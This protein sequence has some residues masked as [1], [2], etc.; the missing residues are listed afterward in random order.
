MTLLETISVVKDIAVGGAS[1]FA[2]SVAFYGLRNWQRELRGRSDFD[3]ARNLA[4]ST[5]VLRD[6]L[7]N[8]RSPLVRGS[9][10]PTGYSNDKTKTPKEVAEAWGHLYTGRWKPVGEA[11]QEFDAAVLESEALWGSEIRILTDKLKGCAWEYYVAIE[12][13]IGDKKVGG[14]DFK[15]DPE[16][17]KLMRSK[18][19]ASMNDEKNALNERVRDAVTGIESLVGPHLR[20]QNS[21]DVQ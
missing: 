15:A 9:E 1:I 11:M 4:R 16:F 7:A 20:R 17:G 13:D 5:F 6:T 3:A 10:F 21:R 18:I 2:A 14:E 12:A 8:A 19:A